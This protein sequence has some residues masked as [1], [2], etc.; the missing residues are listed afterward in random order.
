[1]KSLKITLA[2]LI[3]LS[4]FVSF[5]ST[6]TPKADNL[7]NHFGTE[8]VKDVYGPK[9]NVGVHLRREGVKP[10]QPFTPILNYNQEIN[11]K[12]VVAGDLTN[13]SYDASKIISPNLASNYYSFFIYFKRTQ[14]KNHHHLPP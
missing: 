14:G 4:Q 3:A 6:S 7:K 1:M 11:N 2:L 5:A 10:G 13:A 8:P 9:V 12:E